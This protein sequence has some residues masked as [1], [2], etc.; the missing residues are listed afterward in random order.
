MWQ[1]HSMS[2]EP[3]RYGGQSLMPR[4]E[5]RKAY[6]LFHLF[7]P[8]AAP[9]ADCSRGQSL[10]SVCPM[11]LIMAVTLLR[12]LL[13]DSCNGAVCTCGRKQPVNS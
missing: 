13:L 9:I 4:H 10:P 1:Q 7:R 3:S 12:T 5:P 8:T 6:Q 2:L 11:L